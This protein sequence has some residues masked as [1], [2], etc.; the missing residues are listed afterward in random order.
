[1][2]LG[3]CTARAAMTASTRW[4]SSV[5]VRI[6]SLDGLRAIS[7]AMVL[8]AHLTGTRGFPLSMNVGNALG[9]GELGVRTFF[10]ISGFLITRLLFEELAA[11]GR[12][13]LSHFYLRRTLRIF[14][15]YYA[16]LIAVGAASFTG[17]IQ[18][19]GRDLVHAFTYTSN[20]DAARSWFV[21]H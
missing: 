4:S 13:S 9:L 16:F 7:I 19:A 15:P 5:P 1:M 18:L 10:V 6:P 2:G 20:Y 21:G 11:T 17:N 3:Y 14:P 12:V 8:V